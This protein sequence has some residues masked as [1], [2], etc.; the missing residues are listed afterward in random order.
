MYGWCRRIWPPTL[1]TKITPLDPLAIPLLNT[2]ILLTSGCTVTWAHHALKEGNR[3]GLIQGLAL[4]V[5]LCLIAV[6][7]FRWDEV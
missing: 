6:R 5:V 4:T 2:L 1:P 7:V 3:N